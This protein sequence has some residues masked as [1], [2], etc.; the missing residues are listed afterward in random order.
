VA[1]R[2]Y[3]NTAPPLAAGPGGIDAAASVI[4]V[5]S[6]TGYPTP[7]FLLGLERGTANEE[8]CLCTAMSPTTFT[9]TRA[10]DGTIRTTHAPGTAIEHCVGA[11]EFREANQHVNNQATDHKISG[12]MWVWPGPNLPAG[13]L[14][15]D[16]A[17]YARASYPDLFNALGGTSSPWGL[18]DGSTFNVPDMR[19]AFP[20]G[21]GDSP[22]VSGTGVALGAS[23]GYKDG[24]L[25]QHNHTTDNNN[26]TA[27]GYHGHTLGGGNHGHGVIDLKHHH[28]I[29]G[30]G[31]HPNI[32]FR[33]DG[34]GGGT[35]LNAND[36]LVARDTAGASMP[37]TYTSIDNSSANI[38]ID[39]NTGGHGHSF[40]ANEGG[41]HHTVDTVTGPNTSNTVVDR[42]L[43]PYKGVNWVIK[44]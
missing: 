23:G 42:N 10:Y 26:T 38:S 4:T 2:N 27:V 40:A 30:L 3:V 13:C 7:P 8:L 18:P 15:C 20:M 25:L 36:W 19:Q 6:T 11:I 14:W 9:V 34:A 31:E 44:Y 29:G 28:T 33:A 39:S 41:H 21:A 24:F 12:E 22:G 16:G 5:T 32:A 37:V 35:F 17:S 43:P 1:I